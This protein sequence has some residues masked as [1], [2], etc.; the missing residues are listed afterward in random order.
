MCGRVLRPLFINPAPVPG[1]YVAKSAISLLPWV[2]WNLCLPIPSVQPQAPQRLQACLLSRCGALWVWLCP[3]RV[4]GS[5]TY[6]LKEQKNLNSFFAVMFGLSN[7]AIS[8]LARTWE[9]GVTWRGRPGPHPP[10]QG[11]SPCLSWESCWGRGS[12]LRAVTAPSASPSQRLPHKVRKLYSALERLLVS[13][14]PWLLPPETLIL[15]FSA[16]PLPVFGHLQ[17]S[18]PWARDRFPL[19]CEFGKLAEDWGI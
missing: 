18:Q 15:G 8:R 1:L 12:H 2:P 16:A 6:S 7:S 13:V 3:L 11:Q 4:S 17:D 10:A 19:A 14:G 5:S 9:V